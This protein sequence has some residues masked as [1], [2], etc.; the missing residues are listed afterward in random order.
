ME[1][2]AV[3]AK[4]PPYLIED[5]DGNMIPDHPGRVKPVT[6]LPAGHPCLEYLKGRGYDPAALQ[7]QFRCA[8]CYEEADEDAAIGRFYSLPAAF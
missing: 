4:P 1:G 5:S 3:S 6:A 8:Y 2:T 7:A